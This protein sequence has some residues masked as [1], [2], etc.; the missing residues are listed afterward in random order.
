MRA[1]VLV[2]SALCTVSHAQE[3]VESLHIILETFLRA[4]MSMINQRAVA[5]TYMTMVVE[6]K[7][8]PE[9]YR[10]VFGPS[11]ETRNIAQ[12]RLP[13]ERGRTM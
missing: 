9:G 11:W 6:D 4:E 12:R 5:T 3:E 13:D 1:S 2:F 7:I 8:R 10:H